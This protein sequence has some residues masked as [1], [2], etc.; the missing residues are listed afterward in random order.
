[1]ARGLPCVARQL[2]T[3]G[4]G[5]AELGAAAAGPAACFS[6]ER[7]C[8]CFARLRLAGFRGAW[9]I[10]TFR[11]FSGRRFGFSARRCCFS[12]RRCSFSSSR[13]RAKSLASSVSCGSCIFRGQDV[14]RALS[15]TIWETLFFERSFHPR[16]ALGFPFGTLGTFSFFG[17]LDAGAWAEDPSRFSGPRP[18]LSGCP[19]GGGLLGSRRSRVEPGSGVSAL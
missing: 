5:H 15:W 13:C 10:S 18:A 11:P 16:P 12:C 4:L 17:F 9:T 6:A 8:C 7:S 1:M 14:R 3:E 19:A 2:A